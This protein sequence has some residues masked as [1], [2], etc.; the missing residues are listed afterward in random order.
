MNVT[1]WQSLGKIEFYPFFLELPGRPEF[2]TTIQ[3]LWRVAVKPIN[4]I[5]LKILN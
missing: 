1:H 3:D 5:F 2:S 4:A